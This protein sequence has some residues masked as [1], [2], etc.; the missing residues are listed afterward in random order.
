VPVGTTHNVVSES[1]GVNQDYK[2]EFL[3]E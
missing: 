2:R 3:N 1:G